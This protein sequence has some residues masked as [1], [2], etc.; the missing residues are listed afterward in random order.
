[1]LTMLELKAILLHIGFTSTARARGCGLECEG[2]W[3]GVRG[4]VD[5]SARGCGVE[6]ENE[7]GTCAVRDAVT[8]LQ[9]TEQEQNVGRTRRLWVRTGCIA[10]LRSLTGKNLDVN[11]VTDNVQESAG[12]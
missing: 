6:G 8:A 2:V 10:L 9:L 3:I 4:G 1:M 5:W 12:D 7:N 11:E